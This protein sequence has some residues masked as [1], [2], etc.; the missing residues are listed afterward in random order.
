MTW[1]RV[2]YGFLDHPK[3][4][5]AGEDAAN[6]YLRGLIW[7]NKHLTDGR[8]PRAALRVL[9]QSRDVEKRAERLVAVRLWEI[10]TDGAFY[11]HDFAA[12]NPTRTQVETRREKTRNKVAA[13]REG[14]D[15]ARSQ[16][17]NEP[18][19]VPVC[20]PVTNRVSNPA[21]QPQPQPQPQPEEENSDTL[22]GP[23]GGSAADAAPSQSEATPKVA[24]E[25]RRVFEH[26]QR[27]LEH[28]KAR[29]DPKRT[30]L[31]RRQL[32]AYSADDLCRAID[33][34]AGDPFTRGDN[35]RGKPFDDIELLLRDAQ[36]VERGLRFL[37]APRP[38]PAAQADP[39]DEALARENARLAEKRAALAPEVP[40]G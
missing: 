6:L 38:A 8:I 23:G 26:W 28:P 33:G 9:S 14:R 35:D 19:R 21:P 3:V 39:W 40:R 17:G 10:G 32:K 29:L 34:Y 25:V 37:E 18:A 13:W 20:N 24:A 31:I 4:I 11:V 22:V 7:C 27:A 2:D 1:A 36:H 30:A 16:P 5:E 12:H 15:A